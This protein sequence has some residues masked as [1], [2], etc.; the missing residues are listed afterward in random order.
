MKTLNIGHINFLNCVPFFHFLPTDMEGFQGRIV[1][2]VPSYLNGLLAKGELDI[3]PSSSFEYGRN[4][5]HYE[6]LPDY[7]ISSFGNVQSVLLFSRRPLDAL[8]GDDIALTGE[9]AT[10]INLLHVLLREYLGCRHFRFRVPEVPVETVIE[11]GG[12]ALLIGDRALRA[13]KNKV[14]SQL[15][16][17][18]G[19]LWYQFTGLPFVFALWILRKEASQEKGTELR[20]FQSYL[21]ASRSRALADLN[22][23][24]TMVPEKEWLGEQGLVDYWNCMSYDLGAKHLQGLQLY[25]DLCHKYGLLDERPEIRFFT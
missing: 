7:S 19:G 23:L 11:S 24:A 13:A 22:G 25:F 8:D 17:D 12:T 3:S 1:P 5:R 16:Y 15:I 20:A 14:N 10:S 18:L 21:Q 2:G 4:W 9:S 6:L